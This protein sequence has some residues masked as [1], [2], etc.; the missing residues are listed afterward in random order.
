MWKMHQKQFL[1]FPRKINLR[2]L[3]INL[4]VILVKNGCKSAYGASGLL[5]TR[6]VRNWRA[7]SRVA[8]PRDKINSWR[9]KKKKKM[10]AKGRGR[11]T[12]ASLCGFGLAIFH[13]SGP[14]AY[15]LFSTAGITVDIIFMRGYPREAPD[16]SLISNPPPEPTPIAIKYSA[17]GPQLSADPTRGSLARFTSRDLPG[18]NFTLSPPH[19]H[20][21]TTF[22]FSK[23]ILAFNTIFFTLTFVFN[24]CGYYITFE[25]A[26]LR[27][28]TNQCDR[29]FN[30]I[31][32]CILFNI[33]HK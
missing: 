33:Y 10:R 28:T 17:N 5:H 1:I 6:W 25:Y 12:A 13:T 14:I 31:T 22:E 32:N 20:K 15:L 8:T 21:I 11:A 27:S 19:P 24:D 2:R 7:F 3:H 26:R 23:Y 16:V 9:R 4:H 18:D 30:K 29:R